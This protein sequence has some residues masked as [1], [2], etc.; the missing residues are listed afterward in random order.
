MIFSFSYAN[1][2]WCKI[3]E[4]MKKIIFIFIVIFYKLVI[5]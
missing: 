1:K 4:E 5:N 2:F 3:N